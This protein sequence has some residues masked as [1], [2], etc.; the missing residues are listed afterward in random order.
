LRRGAVP[1]LWGFGRLASG[2]VWTASALCLK[3]EPAA[4][5]FA[6]VARTTQVSAGW[7]GGSISLASPAV[8]GHRFDWSQPPENAGDFPGGWDLRLAAEPV[9]VSPESVQAALIKAGA[10]AWVLSAQRPDGTPETASLQWT[11]GG[12]RASQTNDAPFF[13]SLR[14]GIHWQRGLVEGSC[15]DT[16][17]A[18]R[19]AWTGLF[20]PA[21]SGAGVRVRGF[22]RGGTWVAPF[23][24]EMPAASRSSGATT[25]PPSSP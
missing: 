16:L 18:A 19:Y 7:M 22:V 14:L 10:S 2:G 17:S 25:A 13:A 15:G 6:K 5:F 20:L 8:P 21:E 9:W 12:F 3:E 11:P 1:V 24:I 23:Q 4:A